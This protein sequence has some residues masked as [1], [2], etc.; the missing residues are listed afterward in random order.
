MKLH[1]EADRPYQS[2]A[3]QTVIVRWHDDASALQ[4][5][6]EGMLLTEL[7]GMGKVRSLLRS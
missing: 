6:L 5:S 4:R 7:G 1:F 3:I 2:A